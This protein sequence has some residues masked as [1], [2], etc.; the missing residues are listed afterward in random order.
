M[1]TLILT[2]LL[3]MGGLV[4]YAQ[5]TEWFPVGAEWNCL[6]GQEPWGWQ[7]PSRIFCEKDT[8]ILD[9]QCRKLIFADYP[10]NPRYFHQSGD[11]I[12][13]VDLEPLLFRQYYNLSLQVDDSLETVEMDYLQPTPGTTV[14]YL[15][16]SIGNLDIDGVQLRFQIVKRDNSSALIVEKIGRL[17]EL[18]L[19]DEDNNNYIHDFGLMGRGLTVH[20]WYYGLMCYSDSE[21]H[22]TFTASEDSCSGYFVTSRNLH[23]NSAQ[24]LIHRYSNHIILT[25]NEPI[26]NIELY[27][28]SG[29]IIARNGN[30]Y[31]KKSVF[32]DTSDLSSAI[33]FVKV[34][35]SNGIY[36]TKSFLK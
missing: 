36:G 12:F 24:I 15:V 6:E 21:T 23:S 10:E 33:Y 19:I 31:L 7:R 20:P 13:L 17:F 3:W 30:P 8:T 35:L 22:I 29:R 34:N 1:K 32:L 9:K 26:E 14:K 28:V 5:P 18:D 25:A 2:C 27:D 16:D 11:T 4:A